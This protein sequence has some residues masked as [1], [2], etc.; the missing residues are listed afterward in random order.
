MKHTISAQVN[1]A[2]EIFSVA[3]VIDRNIRLRI[4]ELP[5]ISLYN[6]LY[7]EVKPDEKTSHYTTAVIK[8]EGNNSS[9]SE[10]VKE[11]AERS[12]KYKKAVMVMGKLPA[13]QRLEV[14]DVIN[15]AYTTAHWN[16]L[17]M[18]ICKL[19][20]TTDTVTAIHIVAAAIAVCSDS[21]E[22]RIEHLAEAI[23]YF[24]DMENPFAIAF[25]KLFSVKGKTAKDTK[26]LKEVRLLL[27]SII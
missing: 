20:L 14:L 19:E 1:R 5:K 27:S 23:Q 7:A 2:L 22:V 26:T 17:K 16:L 12:R 13:E 10:T 3:T 9:C 18:A 6:K 11:V 4:I 24:S 8:Y 15:N 25:G 21:K